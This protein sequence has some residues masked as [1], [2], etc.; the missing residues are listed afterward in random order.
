MSLKWICWPHF[1]T[2]IPRNEREMHKTGKMIKPSTFICL[3]S[4]KPICAS[5][6]SDFQSFFSF[7]LKRAK[8][9]S[10][11]TW[12]ISTNVSYLE[13]QTHTH[14]PT[15]IEN[16]RTCRNLV[17]M[18]TSYHPVSYFQWHLHAHKTSILLEMATDIQIAHGV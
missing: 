4:A 17:S 1:V 2:P 11:V 3:I 16:M 12:H 7:Q 6:C 8:V 10:Y 9:F 5:V 14:T 13:K 15:A 18:H